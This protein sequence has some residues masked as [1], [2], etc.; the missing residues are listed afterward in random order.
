MISLKPL[1]D[2]QQFDIILITGDKYIDHPLSGVGV[3]ARVLDDHE[4]SV[5]IVETPDWRKDKDFTRLGKPKLFF[6]ISSGAIDSML[7]N[8]TPLKKKRVFDKYKKYKP[9]K[10]D[11]AV[12]VYANMVKKNFKNSP[13]VIGGVEASLRRFSHYDYWE[14]RLRKS[15]ILDSRADIL[16]YGNAEY[17][18]VEIAKRFEK[19]LPLDEIEG[20][21]IVR[22]HI[23][24]GFRTMPSFEEISIDKKKFC[25]MQLMIGN[26]LN[27][28][29]EIGDKYI[30]QYKNH[31]YTQKELNYIYELNYSRNIPKDAGYFEGMQFSVVT[32]RGCIGN[33]SFCSIALHQGTKI[34]SRS[35]KSILMEIKRITKHKDFKGYIDDLG[36]PSANMYGMDC[37]KCSSNCLLC[38]N[39]DRSHLK[40]IS[41]LK[42]SKQIKGIKKIFIRSGIRYDITINSQEYISE[43]SKNHISGYMK[44]APEHCN[45]NILNLMNKYFP[46]KLEKF[47]SIFERINK[48]SGQY[49]K[50]YF[51]VA[52]PGSSKKEN[53]ELKKF[54]NKFGKN[55]IIQIFTPTPMSMSTCMYYT[56]MDPKTMKKVYVPYTYREKK[57]QK[58]EISI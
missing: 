30:L 58:N 20:T 43:I 14:N 3:I 15:I 51:I 54:I 9:K 41:L 36:G 56:G 44:I 13:I 50:Y 48:E 45:E 34:I 55:V 8:Y 38:K 33:C 21:C 7:D 4:Y 16:G 2:G 35:E 57:D 25:E 53:R 10:P 17:S 32:H 22:D 49:L 18:I 28:A 39:L 46:G 1:K 5:G 19:N 12:V 6:G 11:R 52:H 42:K 27:L 29:Q 24:E 26:D 23:P 37:I 31:N 47:I 40:L